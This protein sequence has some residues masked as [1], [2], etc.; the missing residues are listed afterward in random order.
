MT[1]NLLNRFYYP[2]ERNIPHGNIGKADNAGSFMISLNCLN[3]NSIANFASFK[4]NL[5]TVDF[6]ELIPSR[7]V[8]CLLHRISLRTFNV[9]NLSLLYAFSVSFITSL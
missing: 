9:S 2:I 7:F 8:L 5:S 4:K 3:R 1:N 6:L